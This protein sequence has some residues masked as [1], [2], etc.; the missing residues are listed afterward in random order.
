MLKSLPEGVM[1]EASTSAAES[2]S[3]IRFPWFHA[4]AAF[5]VG[6]V[7][8]DLL[9]GGDWATF[10]D[11][12]AEVVKTLADQQAAWNRGDLD[13]FMA[14]YWKSDEL[15]FC[16][17]TEMTYGWQATYDRFAKKYKGEGKEMGTLSFS[18]VDVLN[19]DDKSA[20]ARGK[21]QL[22]FRDGKTASGRF[23]LILRRIDGRWNIV[24]DHTAAD[25]NPSA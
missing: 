7:A 5:L 2:G 10:K 20:G 25:P 19:A 18:S 4:F 23:T 11:R 15:A 17:G 8:G 24:H 16:G 9:G 3:V 21:Y 1:S 12:K 14:S 6:A 22:R 13:G